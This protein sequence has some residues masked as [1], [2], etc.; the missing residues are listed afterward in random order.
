MLGLILIRGCDRV[1][2]FNEV[3]VPFDMMRRRL[4]QAFH[5]LSVGVGSFV[6]Y[7]LKD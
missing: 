1:L 5:T 7:L 4:K 6:D 2:P 3:E